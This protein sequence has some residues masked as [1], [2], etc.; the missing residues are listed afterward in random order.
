MTRA[1]GHISPDS[2]NTSLT[3]RAA[4]AGAALLATPSA[5]LAACSEADLQIKAPD[6]SAIFSASERY[7]AAL[8]ASIEI[9]R[10]AEFSEE[11]FDPIYEEH[12]ASFQALLQMT[13]KTVAGCVAMLRSVQSFGDHNDAHLFDDW[14]VSLSE[15]G[16]TL[17]SRIADVLEAA[18]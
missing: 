3:R 10:R 13:P 15:P 11:E 4:L 12:H 16:A 7:G 17:L 18:K 2:I 14:L 5:A 8:A 6:D 9:T 1:K